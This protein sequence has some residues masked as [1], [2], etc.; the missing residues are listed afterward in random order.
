MAEVKLHVLYP[1]PLD[2]EKFDRD[3]EAHLRLLHARMQI[4]AD[5]R[6]Y[7]V[8]RFGELPQGKPAYCRM[9]TM[10]FPSA[11]ALQQAMGS[12]EMQEVAADAARISSGG[13]PVVLVGSNE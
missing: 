7:T 13:P 3:Y 2:T 5:V 9:F 6:P 12:R 8:T 4:P 10:P 11:E 1:Y